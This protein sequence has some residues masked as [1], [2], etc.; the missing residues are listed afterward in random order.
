M[1]RVVPF[2]VLVLG[3][4]GTPTACPAV[5][6]HNIVAVDNNV[7]KGQGGVAFRGYFNREIMADGA[8]VHMT[9]CRTFAFSVRSASMD[10]LNEDN[11]SRFALTSASE[12]FQS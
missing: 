2:T 10:A 4:P 7:A 9:W 8:G 12:I 11:F 6:F 3:V 5:L 1:L